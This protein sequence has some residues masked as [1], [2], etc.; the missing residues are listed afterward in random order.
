MT[1][2]FLITG[3]ASGIGFAV[4]KRARLEGAE[5]AACDH[6][7]ELLASA[8]GGTGSFADPDGCY[9]AGISCNGHINRNEDMG[10]AAYGDRSLGGHL[11]CRTNS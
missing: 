9:F 8:W 3:A 11:P 5:V 4:A 6:D 1:Q 7:V 2:R 10:C